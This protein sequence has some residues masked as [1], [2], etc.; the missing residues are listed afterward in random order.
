VLHLRP[1]LV[2]LSAIR[3]DA[4]RTPGKV[5]SYTVAQ[6]SREGFT[7]RPSEGSAEA[8]KRL[9]KLVVTALEKRLQDARTEAVPVDLA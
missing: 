9:F 7:G 6:T 1:D 4:D 3:D 8:G 2:D 5:F